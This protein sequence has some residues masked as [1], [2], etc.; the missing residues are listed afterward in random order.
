MLVKSIP[1][2]LTIGNLVLGILALL[3]AY[4]NET[5]KAALLVVCGMVLDGLDG[6]AARWL[7]AET[8]FGKELDSLSDIVT[9][10]VAPSF[11]MYNTALQY[12]G[13]V[14]TALAV[15]FPV[16]GAL[17]LARFNVQKKSTHYFVGL[18][19]TAAGGILSTMALY[20]DLLNPAQVIL[21]VGMLILS[22][23][24]V[25][26]ARYPNFKRVGFPRSAVV[27]VPLLALLVYMVFHYDHSLVNHIVFLPLALYAVFG[28]GQLARRRQGKLGDGEGEAKPYESGLK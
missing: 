22:V 3:W 18:P 28:V 27:G 21:P 17:R 6:R 2:L 10:G 15:L 1:S 4:Q 5:E 19:I 11:I 8:G 20:D 7:H 13:W 12:D 25:S 24:M 16:C 9:F 14:G 26:R 23:L